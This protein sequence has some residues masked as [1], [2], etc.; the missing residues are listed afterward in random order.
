MFNNREMGRQTPVP[1]HWTQAC[2]PMSYQ[3]E[4]WD[5]FLDMPAFFLPLLEVP[6]FNIQNN[7]VIGGS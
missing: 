1:L 2:L 3:V 5:V 7:L 6:L 4:Y